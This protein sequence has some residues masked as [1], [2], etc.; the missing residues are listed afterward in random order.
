M[1]AL[2]TQNIIMPWPVQPLLSSFG[3][4]VESILNF[5]A[6]HQIAC[7]IYTK[8][9]NTRHI[10]QIIALSLVLFYHYLIQLLTLMHL[11]CKVIGCFILQTF[12][13]IMLFI[14]PIDLLC[15]LRSKIKFQPNRM[16]LDPP[17]LNL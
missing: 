8:R 13:Q 5:T 7:Y 10:L 14:K 4:A 15:I 11:L 9:S 12:F 2:I 1:L 16:I 3:N 6:I 17:Y